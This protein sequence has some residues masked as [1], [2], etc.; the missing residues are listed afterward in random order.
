MKQ[1]FKT[2]IAA[3]V[4][5]SLS[6]SIAVAQGGNSPA[7]TSSKMLYHNGPVRTGIQDVYI[8]F[9]GC[10]QTAQCGPYDGGDLTTMTVL[11][12]FL[13]TVGGTP[14]MAINST[15]TDI[16]GQ[17][18]SPW[19]VFGGW[20]VD[21]SYAHGSDLSKSDIEAILND[22]IGDP[23]GQTDL[24][25]DP[26]GIYIIATT[27]D[28]ASTATG[29]CTPGVPPFHD[30]YLLYGSNRTP[31]I[32]LGNPNR[33]PSV[34]GGHY[35]SVGGIT[36]NGSYPGDV[37]VNNLAHALN[38][39]MTNPYDTGWYDRYGLENADKCTGLYGTTYTAANGAWANIHLGQRDFLLEENWVNDRK[40]RCAMYP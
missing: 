12:D 25:S 35:L 7:K 24:P 10:W 16:S 27:A 9:Y 36:P 22:H 19:L 3:I 21:N 11:F 17:Q 30:D 23:G 32:F 14:Y 18:A 40:G 28:I 5:I 20:V 29:F 6:I 26:Q 37:M 1:A 15:Y 2:S 39:L 4:F 38:G 8:I 31:Y 34:A 33:C 13:S